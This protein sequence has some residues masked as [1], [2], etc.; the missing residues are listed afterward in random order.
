MVNLETID[1]RILLSDDYFFAMC[2]TIGDSFPLVSG[3]GYWDWFGAWI[4]G[5]PL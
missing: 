5:G 1:V 2:L 4:G 3:G